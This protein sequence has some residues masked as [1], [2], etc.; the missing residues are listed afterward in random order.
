MMRSYRGVLLLCAVLMLNI[1]FTQ[2]AIHHY[3]YENYE[4]TIMFAIAN[5]IMVPIACLI[6]KQERFVTS[7]EKK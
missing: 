3:Y 4:Q 2:R 5:V 1:I 7:K 6:Y